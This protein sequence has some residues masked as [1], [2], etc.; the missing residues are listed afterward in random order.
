MN[1]L[2]TAG[3]SNNGQQSPAP[4]QSVICQAFRKLKN[5]NKSFRNLLNTGTAFIKTFLI[6]AVTTFLTLLASQSHAVP[7]TY[8]ENV[9]STSGA[10]GDLKFS[11]QRVQFTFNGDTDNIFNY[12]VDGPTRSS[13]GYIN[14]QGTTAVTLY[15][16]DFV[17]VLVSAIFLDAV[18]VS[19]DNTFGGI[20]FGSEL[21]HAY[22]PLYPYSLFAPSSNP[23]SL[24]SYNLASELFFSSYALS[25]VGFEHGS[26][27]NR[28]S[29]AADYTLTTTAGDFYMQWDGI[30]TATFSALT[31]TF[32]VPEPG[33]MVLFALG[34]G[35]LFLLRLN[36][37]R[38]K[39]W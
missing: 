25:C 8:T 37:R 17:T 16:T 15:D 14:H 10:L 22:E 9:F 12:T 1:T 38:K 39:L 20:G 27:V 7:V 3:R 2:R 18:F 31:S 34:S 26:C 36:R 23:D 13:T 11:G 33:A 28:G 35:I 30:Q 21:N 19:V 5:I 29:S 32:E 24:A 4:D 6:L